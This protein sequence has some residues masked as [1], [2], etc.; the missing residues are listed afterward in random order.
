MKVT[1]QFAVALV[2]TVAYVGIAVFSVY[3]FCKRTPS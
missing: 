1:V 2:L 3:R